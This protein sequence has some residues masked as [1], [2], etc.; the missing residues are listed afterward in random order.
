MSTPA[1]SSIADRRDTIAFCFDNANAP[2]AIVTDITAGIATGTEA[3]SNTSTNC[4]IEP[5]AV[6]LQVPLTTMSR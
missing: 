1:S 5:A 6:Q 2:S 4:A 3:T